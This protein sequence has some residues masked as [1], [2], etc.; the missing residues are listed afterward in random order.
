MLTLGPAPNLEPC[1]GSIFVLGSI[2][3]SL[4]VDRSLDGTKH[5][6]SLGLVP[7]LKLD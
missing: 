2:R 5:M 1:L 3:A 6:P 4:G 7:N